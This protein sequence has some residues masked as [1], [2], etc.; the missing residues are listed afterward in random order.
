[1]KFL[2]R[3]NR[4]SD[5]CYVTYPITRRSE[6]EHNVKLEEA[7]VI[8]KNGMQ[9]TALSMT[10]TETVVGVICAH[11]MMHVKD[12]MES[13]RLEVELPMILEIDNKSALNIVQN[14]SGGGRTKY[15]ELRILLVVI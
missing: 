15:M 6:S 7:V 9:K 4:T 11:D 2:F 13:S 14:F 12:I 3:I 1:M 5:S 10:E 8:C